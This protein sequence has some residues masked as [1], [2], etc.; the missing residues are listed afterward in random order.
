MVVGCNCFY[1]EYLKQSSIGGKHGPLL[2]DTYLKQ[3]LMVD[4]GQVCP[5]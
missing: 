5:S 2:A 3:S 1:R 4:E